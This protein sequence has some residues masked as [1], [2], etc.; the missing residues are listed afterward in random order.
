MA[1]RHH[2]A[3]VQRKQTLVPQRFR[4]V[5]VDDALGEAF[6]DRRLADARLADDDR[7]VLRAPREDLHDAADLLVPPDHRIDRSAACRFGKVARVL[8][9]RIVAGLGRGAVGGP[10]LAQVVDGGIQRLRAGTGVGQDAGGLRPLGERKREQQTFGGDVAVAG[11]LRDVLGGIEEPRRLRREVELAGAAAL[12]PGQ[13]VE[14]GP[15][16]LQRVLGPAAGGADQIGG[17]AFGVVEQDLEQML[18]REALVAAAGRETLGGL[19]EAARTLGKPLEIHVPSLAG[20]PLPRAEPG[21]TLMASHEAR[22]RMPG[23]EATAPYMGFSNS[24]ARAGRT[25]GNRL[26]VGYGMD[27]AIGPERATARRAEWRVAK[28]AERAPGV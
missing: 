25:P 1:P 3:E 14:R 7:I 19:H 21:R 23:I 22:I 11:L 9:E 10:A 27:R 26:G 2:G 5:A 18:G 13:R 28:R 4:H 6:N 16:F 17:K 24:A 15:G 8:P 20:H 12:H